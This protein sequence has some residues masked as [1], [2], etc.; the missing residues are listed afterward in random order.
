MN[1]QNPQKKHFDIL[2]SIVSDVNNK[3]MIELKLVLNFMV[4]NR[5]RKFLWSFQEFEGMPS[6]SF[7]NKIKNKMQ[8]TAEN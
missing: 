6:I 2:C 7:K 4:G 3:Q 5:K 1:P 8:Q